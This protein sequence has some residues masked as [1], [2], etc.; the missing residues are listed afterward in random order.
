MV[1]YEFMADKEITALQQI[2][3]EDI[4]NRIYTIRGVQVM[5]DSDLAELYQIET[6]NLN[7]AVKRNIERFPENFCFQLTDEEYNSL[8]FQIGISNSRGGRRYN[9][10]GFTE[11]GVAMLAGVL[12]SNIAVKMSIDIINA[13]VSMRH[14]ISDNANM[15]QHLRD[16]DLKLLEHDKNFKEIFKQL[17]NPKEAK[18]VLFFKGQMWD[19]TS[20]IEDIISKA[21]KYIILIDGY[22]DKKNLDL[23][24]KKRKN[25]TVELYTSKNGNK[26]TQ[27]EVTDFNNQYGGL[28]VK[29][30]NDFHD[31]FL[32]LDEKELYHSGASIKD[33]GKKAFELSI[34][35]DEKQL[36][37]ILKRLV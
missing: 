2:S 6:F 21:K 16:I 4:K 27:K 37:E 3:T 11:Q 23:L 17:Q 20:L 29:Y 7:K 1:K 14:F 5:L 13:F 18:A 28:S 26:L 9:P 19:A 31:R 15:L 35:E 22:I 34:I 12:H 33:A 24:S 36:Q 10:Y 30:T 8:R 25:V 32:I